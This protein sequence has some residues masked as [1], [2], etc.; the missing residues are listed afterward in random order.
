M[1]NTEHGQVVLRGRVMKTPAYRYIRKTDKLP[2]SEAPG[3][4]AKVK[5]FDPCGSWTWFIS[6]YDPATGNCF[7]LV[8]GFEKELGYFNINELAAVRNRMGLPL[9]RDLHWMPRPLSEC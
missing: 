6:E 8:D 3:G 9:E 1:A 2:V 5:L 7:G 4:L